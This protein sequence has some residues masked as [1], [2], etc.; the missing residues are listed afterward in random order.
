MIEI[1]QVRPDEGELFL[2][3]L[4]DVFHL[5]IGR[6]RSVFYREPLCDFGRKW[7]LSE[8]GQMVSILTTVPLA[9]GWGEAVGIAG[10]ATREDRRGEG[11]AAQ[12]LEHVLKTGRERGEQ[13]AFLFAVRPEVYERVGFQV[14]DEVIR[15][16]IRCQDASTPPPNL[17]FAEI[18]DM[19]TRWSEADPLRLRRDERRW[20]YWK[21]N[22]RVCNAFGG[23]YLCTEGGTVRECVVD[24]PET[25]WPL[26][27][28]T[29]WFGLRSMA[30]LQNVPLV[31]S[32]AELLLMG[33]GAPDVPQMFMTD[34]F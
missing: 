2:K 15:G 6:A 1:R 4:C 10:V 19:Y 32:K 29:D 5:D 23:G 22:L 27:S 34:Q 17:G 11:L 16:R 12:L 21:W 33:A 14:I 8:D 31:E 26:P 13:A 30:E 7:A 25:I 18:A 24:R 28:Q 3:L 20:A 9:F